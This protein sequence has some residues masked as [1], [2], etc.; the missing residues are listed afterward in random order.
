MLSKEDLRNKRLAALGQEIPSNIAA[1]S[2]SNIPDDRESV[3]YADDED[4]DLRVAMLM[5]LENCDERSSSSV[6]V[7]LDKFHAI[8][9]GPTSTFEDQQRWTS[10]GLHFKKDEVQLRSNNSSTDNDHVKV[11]NGED[12]RLNWGLV[13]QFGGPCGVLAVLQA[14]ILCIL[15]FGDDPQQIKA[16]SI[17]T[18]KRNYE[19]GHPINR[20]NLQTVEKLQNLSN[21]ALDQA[22]AQSMATLLVRTAFAGYE[23]GAFADGTGGRNTSNG[24]K[25]IKI[26]VPKKTGDLLSNDMNVTIFHAP[27]SS[28]NGVTTQQSVSEQVMQHLLSHDGAVLK[29]FKGPGGVLLFTWSMVE[30]RGYERLKEDFDSPIDTTLTSQFG[31]TTQELLNLALTGCA[32]SN[33]FNGTINLG[34]GMVCRGIGRRSKVG[35][36]SQLE[37]LRYCQV[38]G[39]LKCPIFPVWVVGSESHFSVLFGIDGSSQAS[40]RTQDL[41]GT[42]KNAWQEHDSNQGFIPMQD[43]NHVLK[44]LKLDMHQGELEALTAALEVCYVELSVFIHFSLFSSAVFSGICIA[45]ISRLCIY[46]VYSLKGPQQWNNLMGRFLEKG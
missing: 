23:D 13:Q 30:T 6:S 36:L 5:S 42:C 21:D 4:E 38:G 29:H 33:P 7:D 11:E 40:S 19:G 45:L 35:Y 39:Y 31:H 8:M 28:D 46:V 32:V 15:L 3:P 41:F 17:G 43:L 14:E 20:G 12:S 44:K 18:F 24:V 25:S 16:E 10:Q 34:E 26:I 27:A 2:K 37:K 9:W 1:T 22:L